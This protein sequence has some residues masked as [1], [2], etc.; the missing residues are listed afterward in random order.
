[1]QIC[2]EDNQILFFKD[3]NTFQVRGQ[4]NISETKKLHE[5]QNTYNINLTCSL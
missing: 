5:N 2:V 4:Q 1:M 3:V